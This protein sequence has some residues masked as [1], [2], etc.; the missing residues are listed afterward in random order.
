[1]KSALQSIQKERILI[2]PLNWGLGHVSRT[3]PIIQALLQQENKVVICCDEA[4]REFY[5]SFFPDAVYE[6]FPGYPFKFKGKGNW[7]WDILRSFHKLKRF[8]KIEQEL[9]Q[10]LVIKYKSTI[11]ISDQRFG[12]KNTK[13]KNIIISHQPRLPIS[14]WNVFA[15]VWN[16]RLLFAF[17]ELWIPDF[18]DHSLAGKLSESTHQNTHYLGPISRFSNFTKNEEYQFEYLAIISGPEP[19]ASQF[20]SEAISFLTRKGVP[21]AIV[22]PASVQI[23]PETPESIK[24][25]LQPDK[26]TLELLLQRSHTIISRCGYSTLMDL[27][28]TG[29]HALLVPT[30]G[31]MEQSYLATLHSKNEKWKFRKNLSL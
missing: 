24:K 22:I 23:E 28:F 16:T 21:S 11:L 17:D 7:T 9:V 3:V 2:S 6:Y 1:V 5:A 25:H 8:L 13:T 4:Q 30:P 29:H 15:H 20:Y 26:E 12:F 14:I 19:Y 27:H 31:Q 10:Q 18:K